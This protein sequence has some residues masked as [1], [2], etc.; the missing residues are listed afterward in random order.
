MEQ[1]TLKDT[2]ITV[3]RSLLNIRVNWN[4][5]REGMDR[6]YVYLD[7]ENIWIV[8]KNGHLIGM[9]TL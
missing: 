2:D 6:L 1:K 4:S 3:I 9:K 5:S 8:P 7:M